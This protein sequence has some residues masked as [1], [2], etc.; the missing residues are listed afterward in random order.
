VKLEGPH[1]NQVL[2]ELTVFSGKGRKDRLVYVPDGAKEAIRDWLKL[3]GSRAGPLFCHVNKVGRVTLRRLSG[4]GIWHILRK[5]AGQAGVEPFAPHDL[6]RSCITNLLASG[7]EI[8]VVQ[9]LA[10][11]SDPKTTMRYDRRCEVAKRSAASTLHVSYFG[12]RLA[13]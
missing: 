13:A 5:R 3:R 9:Q 1:Y 7:T 12:G 4:Q 6:R 8:F 2:N 10:G 11:H